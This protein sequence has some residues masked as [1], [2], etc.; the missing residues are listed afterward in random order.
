MSLER[1][2]ANLNQQESFEFVLVAFLKARKIRGWFS[3]DGI[4]RNY[5]DIPI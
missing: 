1:T 4:T 5:P 2:D 3:P